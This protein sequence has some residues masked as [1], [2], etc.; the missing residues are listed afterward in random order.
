MY[1]AGLELRQKHIKRESRRGAAEKNKKA[2]DSYDEK[3]VTCISVVC[4]GSIFFDLDAGRRT[5]RKR[6][7]I[8]DGQSAPIYGVLEVEEEKYSFLGNID[9]IRRAEQTD[10]GVTAFSTDYVFRA[11]GVKLEI[12]FVSPLLPEDP[13]LIACPCC[14][15]RYKVSAPCGVQTRVRLFLSEEICYDN[16]GEVYA[17]VVSHGGLRSAFV[18]LKR[19]LP[20]SLAKDVTAADWGYYYVTS[21]DSRVVSKSAFGKYLQGGALTAPRQGKR[22]LFIA[23]LPSAAAPT[24]G[25]LSFRTT[26]RSRR[27]ISANG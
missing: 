12:S 27:F 4:K 15:F 22:D 17:D 8:L 11:G 16:K 13:D 21:Q 10:L 3:K 2:G 23:H 19:Q 25:N 20:M 7:G 1:G 18:G 6:Y 9:G 5:E 26:I 24:R 14:Y